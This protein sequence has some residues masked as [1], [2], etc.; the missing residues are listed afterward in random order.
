[1]KRCLDKEKIAKYKE[2][3]GLAEK[4]PRAETCPVCDGKG[5]IKVVGGEIR[6]CRR[7]NAVP[8]PTLNRLRRRLK[9]N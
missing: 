3:K 7:C 1:M 9:W 2:W 5:K 4:V 6:S 8:V